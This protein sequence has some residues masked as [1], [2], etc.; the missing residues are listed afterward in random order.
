M[1][2][3]SMGAGA[4]AQLQAILDEIES[5]PVDATLVREREA[6]D[7]IAGPFN[8]RLILFGAGPLGRIILDGLRRAGVEPLGF[9][10]NNQRLWGTQVNGLSVL[11]PA[12]ALQR[13]GD[14][15]CFVVSI[16]NGSSA[17]R[18]LVGLGCTRIAPFA[19][20]YW[21]Y[22]DVFI[23]NNGIDLPHRLRAQF[24]AIWKCYASLADGASRKEL[25]EQLLWRYWL[26]FDSLSPAADPRDIYFP[27]DLLDPSSEDVFVDC[28]SFDGD[29]VGSFSRHWEGSFRHA[30]ALEPDPENR[31]ALSQTIE[32]TALS[33][34]VTIMPYAAGNE[35]G[36]VSFAFSGSAGSHR[37]DNAAASKV[38]CRK[39]DDISWSFSPTYIKMDIEGSEP[40][41]LRGAAQLL[42]THRPV[43]A[44]CTYHRSEHLWE[45][46]NLIRSICPEYR[47]F[48]RR[49]AEESWE[50][51]CYAIPAERLKSGE[52]R[53]VTEE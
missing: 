28:G 8:E 46:P 51:V 14:S 37:V 16:F 21:K 25:R 44:V 50:G 13:H 48:V 39:L 10:D 5:E 33:D 49:Y 34:R 23:P 36:P 3:N 26:R 24:P 31:V 18:Q 41:A 11:S 2:T 9:A 40:E 29:T 45:I 12:D 38:E 15:A 43:L 52:G 1:V 30:F 17:R 42:R 20:L 7:R 27:F 35:S 53:R 32:R 19:P 6:F 47:T 22:S 4:G